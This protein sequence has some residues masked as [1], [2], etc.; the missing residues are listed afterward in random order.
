M[1]SPEQN[2]LA[3]TEKRLIE[4]L[5]EDGR[6]P[7]T[8]L[9]RRLGISEPTVRKKLNQLLG[10]GIV[11]IRASADPALLG[12][13]VSAF[14]G[15]DTEWAAISAVATV[16]KEFS[17]IEHVSITTGTYDII[18]KASFRNLRH[19]HDFLLK[20]LTSIEGVKDSYSYIILQNEKNTSLPPFMEQ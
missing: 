3:N 14:V 16:L 15:I 2:E 20:D 7:T 10:D 13:E 5:Q 1:S 6:M 19:L 12:Y 11:N 4:L 8:E 9:A 17:F 18:I